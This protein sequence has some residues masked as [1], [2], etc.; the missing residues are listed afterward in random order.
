[1]RPIKIIYVILT[2]SVPII[3]YLIGDYNSKR[4]ERLMR[5]K[6]LEIEILSCESS[7][8]ALHAKYEIHKEDLDVKELNDDTFEIIKASYHSLLDKSIK[9]YEARILNAKKEITQLK[10]N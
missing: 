10:E 4:N 1:M 6:I 7:L 9:E 5:I 3:I 8:H 2:L